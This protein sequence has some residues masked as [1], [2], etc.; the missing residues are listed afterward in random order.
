M[1]FV[2]SLRPAMPRLKGQTFG[3]RV[4]LMGSLRLGPSTSQL[5]QLEQSAVRPAT[6]KRYHHVA[7][8]FLAWVVQMGAQWD[9]A[10]SLDEAVV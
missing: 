7:Q 5:S 4:G 3:R 6:Q 8:Q 10:S 9:D 1:A 2:G